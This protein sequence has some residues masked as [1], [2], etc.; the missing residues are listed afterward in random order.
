MFLFRL[1][2]LDIAYA[3]SR[4]VEMRHFPFRGAIP[5]QTAIHGLSRHLPRD[6]QAISQSFRSLSQI[7]QSAGRTHVKPSDSCRSVI[8]DTSPGPREGAGWHSSIVWMLCRGDRAP[9]ESAH[10]SSGWRKA[11]SSWMTCS[12]IVT[13]CSASA[14]VVGLRSALFNCLDASSRR[15]RHCAR[16][17]T[18]ASQRCVESIATSLER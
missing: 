16:K 5:M 3:L 13:V 6:P 4:N 12:Y 18:A 10:S 2:I 11:S 8:K 15:S 17:E 1:H 9:A 14:R 7:G